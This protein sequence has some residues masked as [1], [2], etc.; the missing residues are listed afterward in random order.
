MATT[1]PDGELATQRLVLRPVAAGDV[2]EIVALAGDIR[3]AERTA[4]MPHPLSAADVEAWRAGLAA[5][6]E[7]AY[8]VCDRDDGALIGV[9]SLMA[10]KKA[11][12]A[13]PV[14]LAYWIGVLHW[15]KGYATEAARR[16]L[17]FAFGDMGLTQVEALVMSGNDRSTRVLEKLGFI[18]GEERTVPAPAR[19]GPVRVR[20]W[21]IDRAGFAAAALSAAVGRA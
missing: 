13:V 1:A 7:R 4:N 2:P 20:A 17:R 14:Q 6:G 9:V 18:S 12:G 19:G 10:G 5:N 16:L 15:G 8:A 3:V 21:Y 11:A